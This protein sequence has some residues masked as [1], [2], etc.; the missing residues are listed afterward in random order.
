MVWYMS[1][2]VRPSCM[3]KTYILCYKQFSSVDVDELHA[4]YSS[5]FCEYPN[6]ESF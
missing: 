5:T 3:K 2:V 6:F 1:E 4:L